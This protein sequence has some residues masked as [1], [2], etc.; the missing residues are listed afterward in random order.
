MKQSV[1]Y[2]LIAEFSKISKKGY[3]NSTRYTFKQ[4]NINDI[5]TEMVQFV[6]SLPLDVDKDELYVRSI[7]NIDTHERTSYDEFQQAIQLIEYDDY[8]KN[9]LANRWHNLFFCH[10]SLSKPDKLFKKTRFQHLKIKQ[11]NYYILD[12]PLVNPNKEVLVS[13][14]DLPLDMQKQKTAKEINDFEELQKY[15]V[16]LEKK[17]HDLQTCVNIIKDI[18]GNVSD[19]NLSIRKKQDYDSQKKHNVIDYL[20]SNFARFLANDQTRIALISN[21]TN[22]K[23][24]T[25]VDK[26]TNGD[27]QNLLYL[28]KVICSEF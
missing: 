2:P 9:M 6:L 26:I 20:N 25:Y 23:Y 13:S 8:G 3:W 17:N 27:L 24:K 21:L 15:A 28:I 12:K 11:W 7:N 10:E 18:A 22:P 16:N 1:T 4:K 5:D 14:K 19:E